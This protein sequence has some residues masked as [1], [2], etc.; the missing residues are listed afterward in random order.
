MMTILNKHIRPVETFEASNKK[1]REYYSQ[2]MATNSWGNCP[3]QLRS[4]NSSLSL[5][6]YAREELIKYYMNKEFP[7]GQV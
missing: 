4:A 5:A 3:F 2:Y 6:S 1:H 7:N